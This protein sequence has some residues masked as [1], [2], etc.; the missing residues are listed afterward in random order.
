MK[1][2]FIITGG[3]FRIGSSRN[4]NYGCEEAY[5]EQIKAAN[6]HIKFIKYLEA[7]Y[8]N[9]SISVIITTYSNKFVEELISIY[10]DYIVDSNIVIYKNEKDLKGIHNLFHLSHKNIS[11]HDYN[12]IFFF[13]I[14]I[15]LKEKL[16]EIFNPFWKTIMFPFIVSINN[17]TSGK[18]DHIIDGHP[19]NSDM[20]LFIPK[21]Y[22]N[23]INHINLGHATWSELVGGNM[24][25]IKH[26][27]PI[28]Y[29]DDFD[30]MINTHHDSDSE[31]DW[32]PL[33]YTVNRKMCE[34]FHDSNSR[35]NINNYNCIFNMNT[36]TLT[37]CLEAQK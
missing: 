5:N 26:K 22:F 1:I 28:L 34:K 16:F 24:G 11:L 12:S 19:K 30:V 14:D 20:L 25:F 7:K 15:V 4:R 31:L 29:Y 6:S 8:T 33:F 37:D 2:L 3:C 36:F 21:K 23:V 17:I 35:F 9:L 10:K 18:I 32:N 13:R 27:S